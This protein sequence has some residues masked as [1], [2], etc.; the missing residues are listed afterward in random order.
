MFFKGNNNKKVFFIAPLDPHMESKQ[1]IIRLGRWIQSRGSWLAPV[2]FLGAVFLFLYL[3]M[4]ESKFIVMDENSLQVNRG[5]KAPSMASMDTTPKWRERL[6]RGRHANGGE[7]VAVYVSLQAPASIAMANTIINTI[8]KNNPYG[9]DVHFFFF[10]EEDP[11]PMP[12]PAVFARASL[13]FRFRDFDH[14]ICFDSFGKNGGQPNRDLASVVSLA[15]YEL[16]LSPICDSPGIA[17]RSKD[18]VNSFVYSLEQSVK[19]CTHPKRWHSLPSNTISFHTSPFRA[20]QSQ[21]NTGATYAKAVMYMISKLDHLEEDFHHAAHSWM[22]V[23]QHNYVAFNAMQFIIIL[24]TASCVAVGYGVYQKKGVSLSPWLV[25]LPGA[26]FLLT[27]AR[28]VAGDVGIVLLSVA[29]VLLYGTMDYS[30]IL[31]VSVSII[32]MPLSIGFQPAMGVLGALA[33]PIQAIWLAEMGLVQNVVAQLLG[34]VISWVVFY[35][36]YVVLD[37]P[38]VATQDF[39]NAYICICIYP[40][41]VW[42]SS[43]LVN[44]LFFSGKSRRN[45]HNSK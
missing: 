30:C 33:I 17:R 29:L 24:G 28:H 23:D 6:V 18:K 41:A 40:T 45:V 1:V 14:L 27:A 10:D 2:F 36:F 37:T 7:V 39:A 44:R 43:R 25:A 19:A 35:Y 20:S 3:P 12:T 9:C 8:T 31:V 11:S 16:S 13:V 4:Y 15:S 5:F 21:K 38:L 26:G 34:F 22:S 42:V 32:F